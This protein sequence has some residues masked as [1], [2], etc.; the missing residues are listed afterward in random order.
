MKTIQEIIKEKD[1]KEIESA[2]FYEYP[3]NLWKVKNHDD[4]TI[5]EFNKLVSDRFLAF[6]K[7]LC[8]TEAETGTGILFVYKS[9]DNWLQH[10][11]DV[12]LIHE[13]ELLQ[14]TDIDKVC[15]YSYEFTEQKRALGF[16]VADNKLTQ[17]NIMLLVTS[18]LHEI[19]FF[20]YEQEHLEEEMQKLD[21]AMENI[22]NAES[23][24]CGTDDIRKKYGI[25]IE[26]E[27]PEEDELKSKYL[28]AAMEYT[29]Y[30]RNIEL[31]R[32]KDS[33]AAKKRI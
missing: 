5:G 8:E 17:D 6:L 18:F 3:I 10:S 4:R 28:M 25:P 27:Y 20:G 12:A 19:S 29:K 16:R 13:E 15:I 32:I 30:C 26:E 33:L 23:W 22:D 11:K 31:K 24:D 1:P 21:K 9:K 7:R 14:E 2:Y